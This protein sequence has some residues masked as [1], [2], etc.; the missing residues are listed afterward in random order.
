MPDAARDLL[1]ALRNPSIYGH[2]ADRFDVLETHISWVLL[3]GDY[4][5]KIKKPL[6][7]GFLDFSTLEKRR[8]Y[9]REELRLNTRLAPDI[10][11]AVVAI[12]G[13]VQKPA[14]DG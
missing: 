3:C 2:P 11:L 9:C 6:D 14:F 4:A 13:S 8:F 12:T 5:Y 10:Y 1:A 7:L